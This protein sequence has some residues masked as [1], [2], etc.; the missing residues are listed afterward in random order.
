MNKEILKQKLTKS[1]IKQLSK[2]ELREYFANAVPDKKKQSISGLLTHN[3][4]FLLPYTK[5]V[6]FNNHSTLDKITN[7]KFMKE[8]I[9]RDILGQ[10]EIDYKFRS[11]E[12]LG[13]VKMLM[14]EVSYDN[15]MKTHT[16]L[17]LI[18]NFTAKG[19]SQQ[20][21][22]IKTLIKEGEIDFD[23]FNQQF[24]KEGHFGYV[25]GNHEAYKSFCKF[26]INL[27]E[28]DIN[29]EGEMQPIAR[30]VWNTFDIDLILDLL[31]RDDYKPRQPEDLLDNGYIN[32]AFE[33]W[34]KKKTNK[35]LKAINKYPVFQSYII[36]NQFMDLL[37][38][39]DRQSITDT[40]IF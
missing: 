6:D 28:I 25:M 22:Y 9:D 1:I 13:M 19:Q 39:E 27:K 2:D 5:W 32:E 34:G 15:K 38:D 26:L 3:P 37:P 17:G 21:S 36:K 18:S 10:E 31:A 23:V 29:A 14:P 7:V 8:L 16:V 11:T 24:V 12:S 30:V 33:D 20:Y 40:F 35:F 4:M